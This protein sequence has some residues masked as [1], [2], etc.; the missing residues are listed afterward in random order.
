MTTLSIT[1]PYRRMLAINHRQQGWSGF[2]SWMWHL[3]QGTVSVTNRKLDMTTA[4]RNFQFDA[5]LIAHYQDSFPRTAILLIL[6]FL[7]SFISIFVWQSANAVAMSEDNLLLS[8]HCGNG[9]FLVWFLIASTAL[10]R[11]RQFLWMD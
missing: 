10:G 2:R 11:N 4:L 8:L 3:C 5:S 7:S 6:F 9:A 1:L